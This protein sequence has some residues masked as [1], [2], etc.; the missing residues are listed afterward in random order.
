MAAIEPETT[1]VAAETHVST[2]VDGE[3]VLL[4]N[5]TGMYQGLNG[6]GP[7]IW[8]LVQEPTTV[9]TIVETLSAEYDVDSQRCE[10]DVR[11]FLQE[12]AA[13][14]LVETDGHAGE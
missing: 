2:T 3:T 9:E 14:Q 6:V 5:E 10:R 1:V 13:E 12:L 11:A 8:E 4:N 7:R